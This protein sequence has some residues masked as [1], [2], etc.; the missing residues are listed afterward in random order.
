MKQLILAVAFGVTLF[1]QST[2][3]PVLVVPSMVTGTIVVTGPTGGAKTYTLSMSPA[4]ILA[5]AHYVQ[6]SYT[7]APVPQTTANGVTI[8]VTGYT[9]VYQDV[10]DAIV[11]LLQG[12]V[13]SLVA[14]YPSTNVQTA[15]QALSAAVTQAAAPTVTATGK[16]Q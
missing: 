11:Q 3:P 15:Q 14:K 16:V 8:Q 13:A 9:P 6:D 10:G 12:Q 1:A 5:L 4:A 2:T 7:T